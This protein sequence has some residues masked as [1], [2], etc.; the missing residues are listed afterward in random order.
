MNL[1]VPLSS[2]LSTLTTLGAQPFLPKSRY[3]VCS[4]CSN[5]SHCRWR[6]RQCEASLLRRCA[7]NRADWTVC[8]YITRRVAQVFVALDRHWDRGGRNKVMAMARTSCTWWGRALRFT[9]LLEARKQGISTQRRLDVTWRSTHLRRR[10]HRDDPPRFYCKSHNYNHAAT[11]IS[12]RSR[13]SQ[14]NGSR[15][16]KKNTGVVQRSRRGKLEFDT[17]ED[18]ASSYPQ[19]MEWERRRGD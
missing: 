12:A 16:L 13:Q 3:N 15:E 9:Q 11:S 18:A 4:A 10:E 6:K 1:R 14:R 17:C 19:A 7:V 5:R 2:L 8:M